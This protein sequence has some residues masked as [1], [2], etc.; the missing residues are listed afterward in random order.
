MPIAKLSPLL[1]NQ[2]AA[3]EVIERPASV[4][5]ELVENSLD[6]GAGRIEVV[7]AEGGRELVRVAD[8]GSGI[9]AD[10]LLMAVEPHATSKIS[11]VDDLAAIRTMG[12]RGEALASIASVSRLRITS[13]VRGAEA[14]AAVEASGDHVGPVTPAGCA[15]GT[16]IEVRNLFFNTPARR[17]FMKST[18]TELGHIHEL[19]A[20]I[21]MAHPAVGFKLTHNDRVIFDHPAGSSAVQR[22]LAIMGQELRDGLLEF[23][24]DERGIA[25]W[26]MAGLPTLARSTAKFQY[27]YVNGRPVR[28]RNISHAMKEAYRG[29][30]E[31]A[32]QPTL[33]LFI[34]VDPS[35]VD[36]NV[37]PTKSEVRFADANAVHGQVL[38]T[39]RQRL[40][41][42]DLTPSADIGSRPATI[43]PALLNLNGTGIPVCQ[44]G[45][46]LDEPPASPQAFVD[47]FRRMDPR[48]KDL[49]FS[50]VRREM[51][52]TAGPGE[53]DG[54][55]LGLTYRPAAQSVMQVHNSY[56]VTQDDQGIVIIDQHALHE[57]MMFQELYD[58]IC[59]SG[60]LESQRLITP[61][62]LDASP[63]R[64]DLLATLGPLLSKIG[65][66][67]GA[68]G[69][70]AIGVQAFPTLLFD[71]G[72]DPADFMDALL[73]RAGEVELGPDDEA[74][75][76]EVLDMMSCKAAVKAGDTL[77]PEE[78]DALLKRR[79][80]VERASNCPHGRPTAIRLSLRD[81]ERQFKRS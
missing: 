49:V 53:G 42:A 69:P 62:V 19:L 18:A 24:S 74:A 51:G 33:A 12:F 80:V 71:R 57:R 13:R 76:H 27:L 7:I 66:E 39:L 4:V 25:L 15:T 61:V 38:A 56:I 36:V 44:D 30:I 72:V 79:E 68:M 28:D 47:Y 46:P 67:A 21:A 81:L 23:D 50:E 17:K 65:I 58:R 5:K 45:N 54:E 26:G 73:D 78:L 40:L 52:Q 60:A 64:I 63:Q 22:C 6:A 8:D 31:P 32:M 14:G 11:S 20:R 34:T 2:I 37:H 55:G 10:E 77:K 16:V 41:G 70:G 43:H 9:G 35:A 1:V 48:Q 29:L 59:G 75:L 3:G